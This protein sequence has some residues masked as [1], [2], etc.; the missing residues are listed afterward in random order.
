MIAYLFGQGLLTHFAEDRLPAEDEDGL[1][2]DA[3]V[4]A[5]VCTMLGRP[6]LSADLVSGG[7]MVEGQP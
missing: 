5:A 6:E 3:A 2:D 4:V 1:E 7:S